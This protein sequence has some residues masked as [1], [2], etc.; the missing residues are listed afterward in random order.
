MDHKNINQEFDHWRHRLVF[1]DN[2][3]TSSPVVKGTCI[4]QHA[5]VS[6]ILEG[7]TWHDV[8]KIFHGISDD[9][10]RA[11]LA[12]HVELSEA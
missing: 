6:L 3:S 7:Y 5:V 4:T 2:I 12:Y 11:C 9:D 1:D 8:K 10:I